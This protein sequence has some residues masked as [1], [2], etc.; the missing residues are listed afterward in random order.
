MADYLTTDT[1]LTSVA[2]AIRTKGGTSAQ[3]T[4]PAGFVSAI[5]AIPTGGGV[6][7][8]HVTWSPYT[9]LIYYTSSSMA[10]ASGSSIN[11]D[12]PIGSLVIAYVGDEYDYDEPPSTLTKLKSTSGRSY[13]IIVLYEVTG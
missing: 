9:T 6:D 10:S 4:Y 1:E 2:N 13:D 12:L 11:D 3:L 8:V 7:T 5:E